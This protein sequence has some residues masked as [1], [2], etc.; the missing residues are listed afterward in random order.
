MNVASGSSNGYT[1]RMNEE[2]RDQKAIWT[3]CILLL[4][5]QLA[6][7]LEVDTQV[8]VLAFVALAGIFYGIDMKWNGKPVNG[9]D[10]GLSLPIDENL[11]NMLGLN[12]G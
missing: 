7:G 11:K 6:R 5:R 2:Y 9:E 10:N 8:G 4:A 1:G 3:Y 12:I